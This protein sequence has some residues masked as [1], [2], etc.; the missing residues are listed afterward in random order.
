VEVGRLI[1]RSVAESFSLRM[2]RACRAGC[3]SG[4]ISAPTNRAANLIGR[5]LGTLART[6]RNQRLGKHNES[7]QF[8]KDIVVYLGIDMIF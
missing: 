7:I 2:A 8:S 5:R 6:S 4:A 3:K 1:E